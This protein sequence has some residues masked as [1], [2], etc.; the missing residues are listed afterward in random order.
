MRTALGSHLFPLPFF[1]RFS[2]SH[3]Q[4][5]VPVLLF[6]TTTDNPSRPS[7]PHVCQMLLDCETQLKVKKSG[8][9]WFFLVSLQHSKCLLP[10]SFLMIVALMLLSA[11][12]RPVKCPSFT[13]TIHNQAV[14]W[15][16]EVRQFT[17]PA[18]LRVKK[19][20]VLEEAD[21]TETHV[22]LYG[23]QSRGPDPQLR[24]I[25]P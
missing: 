22:F 1:W 12:K 7:F 11:H 9:F 19:K 20:M 14:S 25:R 5:I 23:L 4:N 24:K 17:F 18:H 13:K 3:L 15:T 21:S 6:S 2:R 8:F 16:H 10:V